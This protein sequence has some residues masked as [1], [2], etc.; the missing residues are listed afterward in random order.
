MKITL[1]T[2]TYNSDKTI[3]NTLDSV[4]SQ[5]YNEIEHLIID[6]NSSDKTLEIART[7]PHITKIISEPDKGIYDA[8]N[9]GIEIAN[10]DIIGFL[11]SDDFYANNDVLTKVAKVFSRDS[12]LDACYADLIYVSQFNNSKIIR[13]VKS[14]EF[15]DGLFSEGWCPPHPTFF[16]RRSVYD[17]LGNFDLNY[18][19]ASDVELMM[20]FLQVNKIKVCYISEVWV[21]MRMGGTSN[22]NLKTIWMQNQEI[23]NSFHKNNLPINITSFFINKFISRFKQFFNRKY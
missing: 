2:V 5:K 6:N 20:R 7:Y 4:K 19:I 1:I 9:K 10:G 13:Y 3:K 17:R 21:K 14:K 8:M 15:K 12:K 18:H 22:K 23:I 16:V 11:N